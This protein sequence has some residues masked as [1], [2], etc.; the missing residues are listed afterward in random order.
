MRCESARLMASE[1][2]VVLYGR[3]LE[4]ALLPSGSA[5]TC[6]ACIH[7]PHSCT[8]GVP[9]LYFLYQLF[10]LSGYVLMLWQLMGQTLSSLD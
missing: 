4:H 2:L 9:H 3:V 8:L 5:L 7:L 6:L 1:L 10:D